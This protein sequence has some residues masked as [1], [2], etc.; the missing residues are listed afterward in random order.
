MH[1]APEDNDAHEMN[2]DAVTFPTDA[3]TGGPLTTTMTIPS[4][5]TS[6]STRSGHDSRTKSSSP[7]Q[8]RGQI[9]DRLFRWLRSGKAHPYCNPDVGYS[10]PRG[11]DEGSRARYDEW[12][13]LQQDY[14]GPDYREGY[15]PPGSMGKRRDPL[16]K[17]AGRPK[18]YRSGVREGDQGGGAAAAGAAARE[19]RAGR[20][21]WRELE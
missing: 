21:G 19:E 10:G 14:Y 1:L 2:V 5:G 7:I 6:T 8:P 18:P 3:T 15:C 13:E 4:D 20:G 17:G 16:R 11:D 9:S 12:L